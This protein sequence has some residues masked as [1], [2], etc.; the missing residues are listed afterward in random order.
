MKRSIFKL[1]LL[2]GLTGIA[3]CSSTHSAS[4]SNRPHPSWLN[5]DWAVNDIPGT[6]IPFAQLYTGRKPFIHID[7]TAARANGNTGCNSFS[8]P[9][10]I[11]GRHITFS[12]K[13]IMT[14]MYCQGEG[15]TTFVQSLQKID[16]YRTDSATLTLLAGELPVM[17][18]TRTTPVTDNQ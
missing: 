8:G 6:T 10:K 16:A 13:M 3:A 18:L 2:A 12:D 17:Q 1:F 4:Q 7:V 11:K 15:E 9:V 5:G 14:R